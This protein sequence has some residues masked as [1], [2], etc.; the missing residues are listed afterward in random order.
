L[1]KIQYIHKQGELSSPV[2]A[3]KIRGDCH[4]VIERRK[5]VAYAPLRCIFSCSCPT[6]LTGRP[7]V[8]HGFGIPQHEPTCGSPEALSRFRVLFHGIDIVFPPNWQT[9][10]GF[11]GRKV[12]Q[13]I[14]GEMKARKSGGA[15][16]RR[17]VRNVG[18]ARIR[19]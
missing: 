19:A 14:K 3:H 5:K 8:H 10:A 1:K 13:D 2:V 18:S 17:H 11:R 6:T 7:V 15:T 12:V 4:R 16:T 9:L